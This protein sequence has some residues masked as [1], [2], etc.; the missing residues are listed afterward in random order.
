M[1]LNQHGCDW[2]FSDKICN[3]ETTWAGVYDE[4]IRGVGIRNKYIVNKPEP[5]KTAVYV[6][7]YTSYKYDFNTPIFLEWM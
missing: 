1:V 2:H 3:V 6:A 7:C 4:L 5:A